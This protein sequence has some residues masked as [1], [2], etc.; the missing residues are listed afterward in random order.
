V[1]AMTVWYTAWC[2][3]HSQWSHGTSV[4]LA[5]WHLAT[6]F[7]AGCQQLKLLAAQNSVVTNSWWHCGVFSLL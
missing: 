5:R 4:C 3:R 7:H 6:V 1:I 2:F